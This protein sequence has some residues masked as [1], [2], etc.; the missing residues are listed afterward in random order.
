MSRFTS[1]SCKSVVPNKFE[2][3]ILVSQRAR[4]L[5]AGLTPFS[6][7]KNDK[8]VVTALQEIASHQ[9][10]I[11]DLKRLV[12]R[13]STLNITDFGYVPEVNNT[14]KKVEAEGHFIFEPAKN[15]TGDMFFGDDDIDNNK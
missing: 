7:E 8:S 15:E 6:N 12:I 13:R 14:N 1:E 5:S 4:D 10:N 2:L 3:V 11:D 9:L